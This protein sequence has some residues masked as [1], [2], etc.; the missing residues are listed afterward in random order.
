MKSLACCLIAVTLTA[1]G[2]AARAQ[3]PAAA[4][5]CE[6]KYKEVSESAMKQ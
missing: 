5:D 3:T 2:T 1:L 4:V 6:Q